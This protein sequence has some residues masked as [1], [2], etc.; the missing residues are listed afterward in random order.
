MRAA[1]NTS[2]ISHK[3]RHLWT[4]L[5]R[6]DFHGI[7]P[8]QLEMALARVTHPTRSIKIS[9]PMHHRLLPAHISSLL[10]AI[11]PLEPAKLDICMWM[12][13]TGT[14]DAIELPRFDHTT[15][16]KLCFPPFFTLL[17][18][19]D[20]T[21]LKSISLGLCHIDLGALLNRCP[22]LPSLKL[23][24]HLTPLRS[25]HP[26]YKSSS[27]MLKWSSEPSTSRPLFSTS[28]FLVPVEGPVTSLAC[29]S[30][31]HYWRTS[32]GCATVGPEVG[33]V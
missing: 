26:H 31:H 13:T 10:F 24:G 11:A 4:Q 25:T 22:S 33:S 28:V 20:F 23:F 27:C 1:A 17:P 19:G 5:P 9:M 29:H 14:A 2:L 12:E 8:G 6:H 7:S 3:W 18:I 30:Q 32:H 16:I 21:K 15:S